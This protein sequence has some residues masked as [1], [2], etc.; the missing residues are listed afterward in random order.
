M[1]TPPSYNLRAGR[2]RSDSSS[3]SSD[4]AQAKQF[5]T[6]LLL[7]VIA[8]YLNLS[9]CRRTRSVKSINWRA[10]FACILDVCLLMK[11]SVLSV[12]PVM[13]CLS[14]FG[15]V[16]TE[17]IRDTDLRPSLMLA[18]TLVSLLLVFLDI[19]TGDSVGDFLAITPVA[20][21]VCL[22]VFACIFWLL[23]KFSLHAFSPVLAG[24]PTSLSVVA[25]RLTR[26]SWDR[27]DALL[28]RSVMYTILM[29]VFVALFR[30]F[31]TH[32]SCTYLSNCLLWTS[33][34]FAPT[35]FSSESVCGLVF[36]AT[37]GVLLRFSTRPGKRS[38]DSDEA[39]HRVELKQIG[40]EFESAPTET[41]YEVQ[42]AELAVEVSV[43][44]VRTAPACVVDM[45]DEDEL[46]EKISK[47]IGR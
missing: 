11:Y 4:L 42:V 9:A 33:V 18:C 34:L 25:I 47:S 26:A 32:L 1:I 20:G 46:F 29:I 27:A 3:H 16:S 8:V 28:F 15:L 7:V 30:R 35:S 14:L 6:I 17:V 43:H 45:G 36:P 22:G 44:S 10:V 24:L 40:M 38:D 23:E 39:P 31:S 21:S 41:C 2:S 37:V 12:Y 19:P 13:V 5:V